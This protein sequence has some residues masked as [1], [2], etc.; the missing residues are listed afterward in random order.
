MRI[1]LAQCAAFLKE[2]D[3]FVLLCHRD[4]DG[5]TYGSAAALAQ[6]LLSMGKQVRLECPGVFPKNL[7]YLNRKY[8]DFAEEYA[9]AIDV[10]SPNMLGD[11]G[12]RRSRIDLC[13]DHHPT[14]PDYAALTWLVDYA[15]TGEAVYELLKELGAS[16]SPEMATALFTA[17]SSDTGG[18]RFAN[19]TAQT[20]RYA[21]D[22]LELGADAETV[23]RCLFE[24][25]SRGR[26]KIESNAMANA[27]FYQNGEIAVISVSVADTAENGVD[28]SELEGL[29]SEPLRID[30]VRIAITLKEREDGS[31]RVSMRSDSDEADVSAVCRRFHGG[32]HVRASGCRIWDTLENAE[33]M[34]VS[35]CKEE[36]AR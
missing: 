4:P 27:R 33:K 7:S 15:A 30:G 31:V 26:V 9:V 13:I 25:N 3:N 36:L 19:T 32:G 28:E 17:L 8:P 34:L 20:H 16:I 6:A 24:S 10:A 23:R 2:R 21:A 29:A 11:I 18:F 35:A 14:N 22:L 5:D 1:D 12:K